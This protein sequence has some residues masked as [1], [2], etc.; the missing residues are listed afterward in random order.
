[1]GESDRA[2]IAQCVRVAVA[3]DRNVIRITVDSQGIHVS[4]NL[5]RFNN[6]VP[7]RRLRYQFRCSFGMSVGSTRGVVEAVHD[8]RLS[9][10]RLSEVEST[11]DRVAVRPG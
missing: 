3:S 8:E 7:S 9:R 1:M 5:L 11:I 6:E 4:H 10:R 2:Y